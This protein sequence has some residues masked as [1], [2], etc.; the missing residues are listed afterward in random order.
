M[1]KIHWEDSNADILTEFKLV[2]NLKRYLRVKNFMPEI[3]DFETLYEM[4]FI[5]FLAK[6]CMEEI[7]KNGKNLISDFEKNIRN[8]DEKLYEQ[9]E[10]Y[11]IKFEQD[12]NNKIELFRKAPKEILNTI[13]DIRIFALG[14]CTNETRVLIKKYCKYKLRYFCKG[15]K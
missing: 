14:Y 10:E 4:R 6:K 2:V 1:K 12:F 5:S 3:I 15:K 7:D 13:K 8:G 11:R 9:W